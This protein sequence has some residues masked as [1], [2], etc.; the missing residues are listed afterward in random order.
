LPRGPR[1]PETAP[2][3]VAAAEG[4]QH[5]DGR[6]LRRHFP[7][8]VDLLGGVADPAGMVRLTAGNLVQFRLT[9]GRDSY[10]GVWWV[11]GKDNVVQLF[12]NRFDQQ[13]LVRQGQTK[14]LPG[15]AKYAIR[16]TASK[17]REYVHVFA[18]TRP[19]EPIGGHR[20]GPYEV[21]SEPEEQA[22]L[23]EFWR[24]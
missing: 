22:R 2:A 14:T 23:K 24:G 5:P 11:D 16:A 21:F 1:P 3:E 12:P 4:P 9:V 15:D 8:Q 13:H 19:W 17:G 10:V 6:P 7:M 18:T 20:A